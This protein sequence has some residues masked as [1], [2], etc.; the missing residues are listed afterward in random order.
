MDNPSSVHTQETTVKPPI[1]VTYQ[2]RLR[3][4]CS[5][6]WIA[7]VSLY[8]HLDID[9]KKERSWDL[10]ECRTRAWFIRHKETGRVSIVASHCGLRWC[11][12]CAIARSNYIRHSVSEW[13]ET[14]K[15]P[16][17]LTM[18]LKHSDEPLAYQVNR[19]YGCFRKMR[20]FKAFSK[21]VTGG[22]WFFQLCRNQQSGQWHPHLHCIITG[23]YVPHKLLTKLWYKVTNDST[24]IDIRIVQNPQKV[25]DYVARYAARPALLSNLSLRLG[26]ELYH[27]M[28][29][30]RLCG[31]WGLFTKILLSVQRN[32]DMKNWEKIGS[33]LVVTEQAK[34]NAIAK[35][36]LLAYE[37]GKPLA[38]GNSL[39][40]LDDF[41]EDPEFFCRQD[42]AVERPPPEKSLFTPGKN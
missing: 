15:Y 38:P 34:T 25:A 24:I 6:E 37:T 41:L 30:K 33:W 19:L 40:Y 21:L 4:R 29:G 5:T 31:K 18:T 22:V 8:Q 14:A 20:K 28:H 27:A 23:Q 42:L 10:N 1:F 36:I 9:E 2:D 17:F 39:K 11:P 12:L 32:P 3:S 13:L 7:A 16:K 35:R 26:K